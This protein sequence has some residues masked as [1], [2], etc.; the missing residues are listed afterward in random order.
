MTSSVHRY[1]NKLTKMVTVTPVISAS[2]L[3]TTGDAV[4]G[5]MNFENATDRDVSSGVIQAVHL[6]DKDSEDAALE[7]HLFRS[8][9]TATADNGAFDPSDTEL[10]TLFIGTVKIPAANYTA[11]VDNSVATVA[12]VNLPFELAFSETSLYG[13]LVVRG[14][15]TYTAVDDIVVKLVVVQD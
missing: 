10:D 11:F 1:R 9:F 2:V 7:L 8:G 14:A 5:R 3:Y 13:Q 15:P 4:G 12:N 6:T